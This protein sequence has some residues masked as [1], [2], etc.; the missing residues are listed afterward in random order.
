MIHLLLSP[1]ESRA[2]ELLA[3]DEEQGVA[4]HAV[5]MREPVLSG[6][7]PRA[8]NDAG[9]VTDSDP[10]VMPGAK[11]AL[12]LLRVRDRFGEWYTAHIAY[13]LAGAQLRFVEIGHQ[14]A[15][16]RQADAEAKAGTIDE[17]HADPAV[18]R[19]IV[20]AQ[21]EQTLLEIKPADW[22]KDL[23]ARLTARGIL[24]T[25]AAV[26]LLP[27]GSMDALT[28]YVGD[29]EILGLMHG[30]PHDEIEPRAIEDDLHL[31]RG[32]VRGVQVTAQDR[33]GQ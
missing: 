13:E 21:A 18:V 29:L 9:Q 12:Y 15:A 4:L 1:P 14:L 2:V 24:A 19:E 23:A 28:S 8:T 26:T 3:I 30:E 6:W 5:T 20:Q 10:V 33:A 16:Q 25:P 7:I 27:R 31:L 22:A 11:V 32:L 17:Q